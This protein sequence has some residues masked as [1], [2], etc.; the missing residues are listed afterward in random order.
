VKPTLT[1]EGLRRSL[2]HYLSTTFALAER[3]VREALGEFLNDPEQGIFRGP[4]LRI[5][6]PF[7]HAE[8]GWRECLGWAPASLPSP[9]RH[10]AE[11]FKRLSTLHSP[12]EPTLITTGTGSG[13]TESFLI[14]VLDHCKRMGKP[15]V[16]AVLLYPMNALATDQAERIDRYLA[17][18]GLAGVKAGL[19][20]GDTPAKGFNNVL[21]DRT[22]IRRDQPDLLITNYK[23]LDLLLQRPE[24]LDLW[25][26][27]D[28]AYVVV[29]EFHSYDG[30]QG[31][32]VAMLLR[33]LAAAVGQAQPGN[34]MGGICPV[35]TS[36]TLGEGGDSTEIRKVAEQVFGVPFPAASVVGEDRLGVDEFMK[37]IDYRLPVPSPQE[38]AALP[39]PIADPS[40]IDKI[41]EL[42]LRRGPDPDYR[43]RDQEQLGEALRGHLFTRAV[44]KVLDG[45]PLTPAE[46]LG[47]LPR[48]G[49]YGWDNALRKDPRLAAEAL[50][51]FVGLLAHARGKNDSP[52]LHIESHLWVRAVSRLLRAVAPEP[53][54]AWH[55]DT[56]RTTQVTGGPDTP[57][58][59]SHAY[60]PAVHCRHC[61]RSGWAAVS[62]LKNPA[63]LAVS[64]E[65][66]YRA[67]ATE[68]A[69]LRPLIAATVEEARSQLA[70][71]SASGAGVAVLDLGGSRLRPLSARDLEAEDTGI[72]G[73]V[74]VFADLMNDQAARDERCPA[75]QE[76]NGTLFLGAG[77]ATLSSVAITQLFTGG[78]L[79]PRQR[80]T[81]LFNDSTQDAAHRAGFIANRSYQFSLR[82]L[83]ASQLSEEKPSLLNDLIGSL[84]DVA[85]GLDNLVAVVPPD[86][87]DRPGIHSLLSSGGGGSREA[88]DLIGERLA[89]ATVLEFGLH[90][91]QGRTL[92]LTRTAA[93]EVLLE[94]PGRIAALARSLH[95]QMR[96]ENQDLLAPAA[97]P[98]NARYVAFLR[99]ILE[100]LRRRGAVRHRWL[101]PYIDQ[102]GVRRWLIW[103]GRPDGMPAF[104]K[105]RS[106]P[107]FL[108]DRPKTGSQFKVATRAGSW[109]ED[110]TRR[111]L[112][113]DRPGA[114]AYLTRLLPVLA[115]NG[116]LAAR[117]ALDGGTRVYGLHPG[118][119]Q[120][121]RLGDGTAARAGVECDV[122]SWEQTVH[123]DRIADWDGQP[124]PKLRC[125]GK[126]NPATHD[127][128]RKDYYRT[129]YR[130]SGAFRVVTAEHTGLLTRA[131]REDV[132]NRFKQ[133]D[134]YTDPNVLSCTPTLELGIDIGDL[135]AVILAS[136]PSGPANYV[137][138]AG[139]AGRRT[140][141]ALVLTIL[142]RRS[143][144]QYY[145]AEPRQM[146]DGE[147]IP[148]GCYLSAVEILRRQYLAHLLDL[149]SRDRF[150]GVPPMPRLAS[151]LFGWL[152]GLATVAQ[153]DG[154]LLA[155][156]FLALFPVVGDEETVSSLTASDL[157]RFALTGL[158]E[159]VQSAQKI[160][161]GRV[162][163]LRV[164]LRAIGEAA[165]GL[166]ASDPEQLK[167]IKSLRAER[168]A[169]A[170]HLSQIGMA[171]AHATMVELGLLPNYSLIDSR[172]ALEATLTW[173]E[174]T[175]ADDRVYHS[176]LREYSRSA[177]LALTELAPGSSFYI[178]G[179]KHRVSG[180]DI[181]SSERP[182]WQSWRI[183]P[184]CGYVRTN[185]AV[186][187]S[188]QCPRC[189]NT[190][191]GDNE[192]LHKVL[193]PR[194][195]TARDRRDDALIRDDREQRERVYYNNA[196][197]V[198]IDSERVEAQAWRH[199][200]VTFGADFTRHAV[201]RTFNLGVARGDRSTE[202]A[203]AGQLVQINPFF[204]CVTCGGTTTNGQPD[205]ADTA[206]TVSGAPSPAAAHHQTWC[207]HYRSP[208]TAKH[209]DLI[210]AHE[211][212]T[213][214]LR[215]LLPVALA[216]VRERLLSFTAALLA[217]IHAN[218][219][220]DPDHLAVVAARMP[221]HTIGVVRNFLVLHDTLPGGTGYLHRLASSDAFQDV[222]LRAREVI[223]R[224]SCVSEGR[225]AC[226]RCLL[227]HVSGQ[228]YEAVSRADALDLL[229]QL[230]GENGEK[231]VIAPISSV[232]GISLEKQVES[233]LESRFLQ[234]LLNWADRPD[235]PGSLTKSGIVDGKQ[236]G[237]LRI[238]GPDGAVTH[239]RMTLQNTLPGTRP[240]VVFERLDAAR[241]VVAVY[242]DGY[243]YHANV[244]HNRLAND[245]AIRTRLRAQGVVV[246][247]LTWDDVEGWTGA[248][249]PR[250]WPP[251][252]GLAQDAA[253]G[254]LRGPRG[255]G[256]PADLERYIWANPVDLLLSFLASPDAEWRR[257]AEAAVAGLI[258]QPAVAKTTSSSSGIADRISA[259]LRGDPL[260]G[261]TTG[262]ITLYRTEDDNRCPITLL[263]DIRAG[264]A[265]PIV[266]ALTVLD[267]QD[268]TINV[269]EDAHRRRWAAWLY[270]GNLLQFL[271]TGDGDGGQL[272]LSTLPSFDPAQ[273]AVTG[274][275]GLILA[276]RDQPPI[277]LFGDDEV[278]APSIVESSVTEATPGNEEWAEIFEYLNI[279]E[280]GLLN[281]AQELAARGIPAPE[282][283]YELGEG[284]WQ[285]ELA[286]PTDKIGIVLAAH[287][288]DDPEAEKRDAA[289]AHAGWRARPAADW[290][291]DSL[292]ELI[293]GVR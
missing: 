5:R 113:L 131:Q 138:R 116:V 25:E 208:G 251:Y 6:T 82:S 122:C 192:H 124:C 210:L 14:P 202:V 38:L 140:G 283:G 142:D 280:P 41:A 191:I 68:R 241:L 78:Y 20:I 255:D 155:K 212:P 87:Y 121:W 279:E 197:A 207:R 189:E 18:A 242:L 203:F 156:E 287:G 277:K 157:T 110:W 163:D 246:F 270:W 118:H 37:E 109:Y 99:G 253:R 264:A 19:Y 206:L 34:P 10:Q 268:E 53:I 250:V 275:T 222:L 74:F 106:A 239:W 245:A 221:D 265:A 225:Q 249:R 27:C 199:A 200:A 137:Q 271:S 224:C 143:R 61:G 72:D 146:I 160:W 100:Q 76:D 168:R 79:K 11:A 205:V 195:V 188:S 263:L 259:A 90:S 3:S 36:A 274:G 71:G 28:L 103:G 60:L 158:K 282:L 289:Y 220:G 105:G 288:E 127:R 63:E 159:A 216:R 57:A 95:E 186:Q 130:E 223:Q 32:D 91:R 139:R 8:D 83:L 23:M 153:R 267:D 176:E 248:E 50:A 178:R 292:V 43:P 125:G 232:A 13:K 272:A 284:A 179:Y 4:Y 64:P 69:R 104:P 30:A 209:E 97:L 15:G 21:T 22:A 108:L 93:A 133:P 114:L 117:T 266:T 204:T 278:I 144:D 165:D 230:L 291:A 260:P 237:D 187:D 213:E 174:K 92:E 58:L 136:L 94:D 293:K 29:D 115:E 134:S 243:R 84:I 182:S 231:W 80:K 54:F 73:G 67:S 226:H 238:S 254:I 45:G 17:D 148:P 196:V 35:A 215:I 56:A 214:A 177:K 198:D 51:R 151:A 228:D 276:L 162:E 7:R 26:G 286:W 252:Q 70:A 40:A 86:L 166:V 44:L 66:I 281:L 62:P 161:N 201:I 247:Q 129:L 164:R 273:L 181:G 190:D 290:S 16:K 193:Q 227:R 235:S 24:D 102:A 112:G 234:G 128:Y 236:I 244:E 42:L 75:C 175:P 258:R 233:E 119:I 240:D 152:D 217:G 120:V 65:R 173:E 55:G 85:G 256:D 150:P 218:Y 132:E 257:R 183:C 88:W 98:S 262:S 219:G 9:Y 147:I 77:I 59:L 185:R 145:L 89:F 269:D 111:C 149:V 101:D 154:A 47:P 52:F 81:L 172:T 285:A 169:V 229:E 1:A 180:L 33:R 211:L 123:S 12:A 126:L 2:T 261:P 170:E 46:M 39:D 48:D 135:S 184:D 96:Q 49:A 194:R 171:G 31:T 167:V 107:A 141:N